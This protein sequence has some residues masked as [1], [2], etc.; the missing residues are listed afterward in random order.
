MKE[1]AMSSYEFGTRAQIA[2]SVQQ[3][4]ELGRLA[5]GTYEGVLVVSDAF[6]AWYL[7]RPGLTPDSHFVAVD[8]RALAASLFVTYCDVR[9]GGT[10]L[11]AAF[12][13]TVMAHPDHRRRGLARGL[14]ELAFAQMRE[15]ETDVS[16][17]NT[18]PDSIPYHF[19]R[20]LGYIDRAR[21]GALSLVP[22]ARS[23]SM[24]TG[25]ASV[26]TCR[27]AEMPLVMELLNKCY[28]DHDGYIPMDGALW[29]WRKLTKPR[30][31][32]TTVAIAK[33]QGSVM[34][35]ATFTIA[36]VIIEG[37]PQRT[38]VLT[39]LAMAGPEPRTDILGLLLSTVDDDLPVTFLCGE[40]DEAQID[41]CKQTGFTPAGQEAG[42]VQPL[43][44]AGH[45]VMEGGPHP[46][47]AAA[48]S[49]A[50]V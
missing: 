8:G 11:E 13:D 32:P 40:S 15:R 23:R 44:E 39:D 49:I 4:A 19:Y 25:A 45:A 41:V 24:P 2:V 35:A 38:A 22:E 31:M 47:Y 27:A 5:F 34:G 1:S 6:M 9:L 28:S 48:E 20:N 30:T 43:S 7:T 37:A 42:L 12:V 16:I 50:G 10:M 26:A 29:E 33:D 46:W 21:V 36:D 14:F 18:L 3:A 17:L